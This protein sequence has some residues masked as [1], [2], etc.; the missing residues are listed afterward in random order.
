M[1]QKNVMAES[2][3]GHTLPKTTP[4]PENLNEEI[5]EAEPLMIEDYR[6][7]M[8]SEE[9][10]EMLAKVYVKMPTTGSIFIIDLAVRL[11]TAIQ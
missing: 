11:T 8:K 1:K 4:E 3:Q 2:R 9:I 5:K 6:E 7:G 10:I